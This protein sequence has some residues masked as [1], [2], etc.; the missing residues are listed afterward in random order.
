[1]QN[2]YYFLRKVSSYLQNHLVGFRLVEA[3]SQA[4]DE[5]ILRFYEQEKHDFF[6]I[7]ANLSPEFTCL[8]FPVD[9]NRA[10]QNSVDLFEPLLGMEVV[11]VKQFLNERCFAILFHEGFALLFKMYGQ[12]SNIISFQ[13]NQAIELFNNNLDKDWEINLATL[14]RCIDQSLEGF[15]KNGFTQTFPTF[16]KEMKE[17]VKVKL[18]E[19]Q[20]LE[21]QYSLIQHTLALIE[22]PHYYIFS[23]NNQIHFS[24]LPPPQSST[25][26]Q[27]LQVFEN[28]I[29]AVNYFYHLYISKLQLLREKTEILKKFEKQ[30]EKASFYIQKSEEK[31]LALQLEN[32]YEEIGHILMANL[33]A[34]PEK[35]QKIT[36]F[37]FYHNQDIS[38]KL[39]E[40]LSPQKNAEMY[41]KKAKNQKI[42]IQTLQEN[43]SKKKRELE[44]LQLYISEIQDINNVKELRKYLKANQLV[45]V[46]GEKE[47]IP[48]RRFDCEGFEILVGKNAKNNDLLTQK[49]AFKEDMWLH[50]RDVSGSHV[51]IKYKSG[52]PFPATVIERAAELAAWYSKRK[53]DSLCPV[54][55][56]PKKFVRKPKGADE[57]A[58]I[59]EKEQVIM[60]VP[61]G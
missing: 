6:Y 39:K 24:L 46:E 60:V 26:F 49:Y 13:E 47:D 4:K 57:G 56:T 41:Y 32:R 7:R 30:R 14:D 31:L 1:V 28:P 20:N 55:Y 45:Q 51:V 22:K 17:I 52:K 54:V 5:L 35:T 40:H 2:N 25:D 37:D 11:G 3:F 21:N 23:K 12:R 50:A 10:R 19:S 8:S 29:E 36:L 27:V 43:I 18:Q 9:F 34:I 38:I 16:D 15:I 33:Q 59:V 61:K 58:V 48:F 44:N 53:N 42:E